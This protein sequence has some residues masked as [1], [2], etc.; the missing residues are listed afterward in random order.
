FTDGASSIGISKQRISIEMDSIGGID[1]ATGGTFIHSKP[2]F[3]RADAV[4][5]TFNRVAV[6]QH[7]GSVSPNE[8]V[9]WGHNI[10]K[11]G[12]SLITGLPGIGYSLESNF[13]PNPTDR[14][15]ESHEFYITPAGRQI[16][17]KSYTIDTKTDWIDFYHTTDNFYIKNPKT[18]D[19]YFR[20]DNNSA[21]NQQLSL[22]FWKVDLNTSNKQMQFQSA[23]P[24]AEL[25]MAANWKSVYLPGLTLQTGGDVH[26][27]SNSLVSLNDKGVGLG[28]LS[29]RYESVNAMTYRGANLMLKAGWEAYDSQA[30]TATLDVD[31]VQ[32]YNQIRLRKPYTPKNSNDSNGSVGDV[33]WDENFMYVKTASGWKR[34]KLESF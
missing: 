9:I 27:L 7:N 32:G 17:L 31:G 2:I 5:F 23:I 26:L 14:W 12:G 22:G 29:N 6:H 21:N 33:A 11:G 25:Y 8:V 24:D 34:T 4:P 3:S 20:L 16:R 15:V 10:N 30:A 18:G 13:K 28:S 1:G 19:V